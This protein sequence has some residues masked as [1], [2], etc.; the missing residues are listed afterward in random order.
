MGAR[1][2]RLRQNERYRAAHVSDRSLHGSVGHPPPPQQLFSPTGVASCGR[3]SNPHIFF[4]IFSLFSCSSCF[5]LLLRFSRARY[6]DVFFFLCLPRS[7]C[8]EF[9]FSC[10]PVCNHLFWAAHLRKYNTTILYYYSGV[11]YKVPL[12]F[13]TKWCLY[14]EEPGVLMS[15]GTNDG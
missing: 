12:Y 8:G 9:G 10:L 14:G 3:C 7:I 2:H 15:F 6:V 1:I 13:E 4:S 5:F 11:L